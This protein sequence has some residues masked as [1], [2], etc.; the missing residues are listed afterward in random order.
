MVGNTACATPDEGCNRQQC[1]SSSR[2]G[3]PGHDGLVTSLSRP[4]GNVTGVV[5]FRLVLGAKRLELL[6]QLVPTATPSRC[7]T[8][9]NSPSTEPE[10][11]DVQAAAAS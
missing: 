9:P 1:R 3:R 6:R 11:K 2:P 10:R 5:F 8:N 7:S 4:G